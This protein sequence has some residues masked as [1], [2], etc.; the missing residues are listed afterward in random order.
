MPEHV[1]YAFLGCQLFFVVFIALHDWFPSGQVLSTRKLF[2]TAFTGLPF[3]IGLAASAYY[4][5]SA[6]LPLWVMWWLWV[7]YGSAA[8]GMVRAWWVPM[9]AP[10]PMI[11]ERG[12]AL[13]MRP[14]SFDPMDHGLGRNVVTLLLQTTALVSLLLLGAMTFLRK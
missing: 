7:C 2:M 4:S 14:S 6:R 12:G 13:F 5:T 9:L 11:D 10:E 3:G 8:Y 1:I